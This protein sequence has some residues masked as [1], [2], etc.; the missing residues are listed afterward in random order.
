M[1]ENESEGIINGADGIISSKPGEF[2]PLFVNFTQRNNININTGADLANAPAVFNSNWDF[3]LQ[4]SSPALSGGEI[5]FMRH[6]GSQGILFEGLRN[7]DDSEIQTI[8]LSPAPS[9]YFG[10]FGTK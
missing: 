4:I 3:H 2:D 10:A 7:V 1:K 5:D 6:F 9:V 8:Y